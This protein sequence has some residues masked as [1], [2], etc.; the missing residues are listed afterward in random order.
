MTVTAC[1]DGPE[2]YY[3]PDPEASNVSTDYD[4]ELEPSAAALA[5]IPADA[6]VL[7][8][9]DFDQLRLSLGFGTLDGTSPEAERARFWRATT[10]S[11]TLSTGVLRPVDGQLRGTYGFGQDDV[12]WEARYGTDGL[13]GW[14]LALHDDVALDGVRRAIEEEV[15]PLAGA[16][17]DAERALVSSA[18]LPEGDDSWAADGDLASLVGERASAT[19]VERGCVPF[20]DVFGEGMREEL[21]EAPAA[22]LDGLE[23]LEGFSVAFGAEVIT[24]RLGEDRPDVFTR[25]GLAEVM[26]RTRP[27]FGVGYTRGVADP[28][29][30]RLGF[31]LGNGADAAELALGRH[32]PFAVCAD[33]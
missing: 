28:S 13:D 18:P 2:P 11:P 33:E 25:L 23:P 5:L 9:T 10:Q 15:G 21:A 29:T 6:T 31:D 26:P 19:Y 20:D 22:E 12:S 32:L 16:T 14:V 8:V 4:P 24:V 7:T 27:E 3:P 1:S 30:G 17:L